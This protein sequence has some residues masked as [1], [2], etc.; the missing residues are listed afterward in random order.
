MVIGLFKRADWKSKY[1]MSRALPGVKLGALVAGLTLL[2]TGYGVHAWTFRVQ[3]AVPS[4]PMAKNTEG[5]GVNLRMKNV[6]Y[7][8]TDSIV[9]HIAS[10]EG[11]LTPKPDEMVVFDDKESFG[12]FVNAANV[13]LSPS[14]LS[15]DLNN[16]V[17]TR[18]DA[19]LKKLS[20]T[21]KGNELTVRGVLA[22]K[23]GIPF[24]SSGT[25]AVTPEGWIR[26]HTTRVK[27]L[28]LPVKGLMDLLGLDTATLLKNKKVAGVEADKDDLI[29]DPQQILPPPPM[30]GR[31]TS[32][33][34]ENGEV[35]LLFGS[36]EN[37]E[38]QAA[39]TNSCGARN[40]IQFK[41]GSVR[42]GKLVMTDTDLVLMDMD[43]ADPFDF[44]FDHYKDQLVAG[45]S[46]TTKKG[47]LCS[48]MPDYNKLKQ[49]AHPKM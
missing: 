26:V 21:I 18:P 13:S 5:D 30:R 41:G 44:A 6:D 43:P 3:S 48:H 17:F 25:L 42:F 27:A 23:G 34:V 7:H 16:Y 29:L 8:L 37:E 1:E 45:Y 47:G 28:H 38:H 12:L 4:A 39:L 14:A 40:Y 11:R 22:S 36:A 19:P 15:E 46:K 35:V 24:E 33:K 49:P 9:L 31:L 2:L 32:I 10:L 20:A